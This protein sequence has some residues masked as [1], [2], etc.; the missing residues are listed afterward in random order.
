MND[1]YAELELR[2]VEL[3]ERIAAQRV[4][5]SN[6]GAKLQTPLIVADRGIAV[7]RFL[8]K[9]PLLSFVLLVYVVLNRRGVAA[10]ISRFLG[11]WKGYRYLTFL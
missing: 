10:L 6:I 9:H 11:I 7:G 8:A 3:I 1:K 2:R 5:L 4:Q